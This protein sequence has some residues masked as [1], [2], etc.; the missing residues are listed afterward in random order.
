ML[1]VLRALANRSGSKQV[2]RGIRACLDGVPADA[3][4]WRDTAGGLAPGQA[5][6]AFLHRTL[7][8]THPELA[9]M[10]A[11]LVTNG[12]VERDVLKR[13]GGVLLNVATALVGTSADATAFFEGACCVSLRE[14]EDREGS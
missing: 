11:C 12:L 10:V 9:D 8:E 5:E 2:T 7:T 14:R 3:P 6:P 4:A 1:D 13:N